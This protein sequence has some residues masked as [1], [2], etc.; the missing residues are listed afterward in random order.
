M[1]YHKSELITHC[2]IVL[3][4]A[5]IS[6]CSGR[7][8]EES[9]LEVK[10]D[11][12]IVL[13]KEQ[14]E[15]EL[16]VVSDPVVHVFA[17]ELQVTGIIEATPAGKAVVTTHISGM[18]KDIRV[19]PGDYVKAGQFLCSIESMEAIVLQQEYLESTGKL[20][21]SS[22]EYQRAKELYSEKVI[23]EKD[24]F[25][26][27]AEY[28][29]HLARK[30]GLKARLILLRIDP[31]LVE[32]GQISK[33]I[34]VTAPISGFVTSQWIEKG[35]YIIA[36]EKMMEILDANQMMLKFFVFEKDI[37]RINP[38]MKIGFSIQ[39]IPVELFDATTKTIG[40]SVDQNTKVIT[41]Y[42]TI[43]SDKI[44]GLL[45]EGMFAN[46]F[47]TLRR[48]EAVALPQ[49]AIIGEGRGQ[50]VYVVQSRNDKE[51]IF[52]KVAV[53]TGITSG[54]MTE[55]LSPEGLTSVLTKGAWFIE[56]E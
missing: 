7:E 10:S 14:S 54:G 30:E 6:G 24:F 42:A 12:L 50:Y 55:I 16:I 35:K 3:V 36:S 31:G 49:E 15:N 51:V 56:G 20:K 2:L 41:C 18:L 17:E 46:V 48:R 33:E 25:T 21:V 11:S 47:I 40:K 34:K 38:G 29:T 22:A 37:A 8:S 23:S 9:A 5:G 19:A 26:A 27:G 52:R 4:A 44:K 32:D 53:E 39:S 1:K 13:S 45:A 43:N 28:K